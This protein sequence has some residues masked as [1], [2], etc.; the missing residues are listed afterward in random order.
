MNLCTEE[1]K[2]ECRAI[3]PPGDDG[4]KLFQAKCAGCLHGS[5]PKPSLSFYTLV[6][7]LNLKQSG[8][9]FERNDLT[10]DQWI[11]LRDL[12]NLINKKAIDEIKKS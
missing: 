8:Y 9:P 4:E 2:E 7:L 6:R 1:K 11:A 10:Y 3:F 12:E 5:S